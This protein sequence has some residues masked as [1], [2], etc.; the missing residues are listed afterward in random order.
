[1]NTNTKMTKKLQKILSFSVAFSLVIQL[2]GITPLTEALAATREQ[3]ANWFKRSNQAETELS[4][5]SPEVEELQTKLDAVIQTE[6]NLKEAGE[7]ARVK[8][9]EQK[10]VLLSSPLKPASLFMLTEKTNGHADYIKKYGVYLGVEITPEQYDAWLDENRNKIENLNANS[11]SAEQEAYGLFYKIPNH[12]LHKEEI[13]SV[14]E[15][16]SY[17]LDGIAN[18]SIDSRWTDIVTATLEIKDLSNFLAEGTELSDIGTSEQIREELDKKYQE[19]I[20][21]K[22]ELNKIEREKLEDIFVLQEDTATQKSYQDAS[23]IINDNIAIITELEAKLADVSKTKQNLEEAA[24][25]AREKLAETKKVYLQKAPRLA[26]LSML[27][28]A[29]GLAE[30]IEQGVF[31]G[32][33]INISKYKELLGANTSNYNNQVNQIDALENE[34][35]DL[36]NGGELSKQETLTEKQTELIA[37]QQELEAKYGLTY[38]ISNELLYKTAIEEIDDW[39]EYIL[40][41][42]INNDGWIDKIEIILGAINTY[43]LSDYF[44]DIE[45]TTERRQDITT[46]FEGNATKEELDD[47]SNIEI[48]LTNSRDDVEEALGTML[49]ILPRQAANTLIPTLDTGTEFFKELSRAFIRIEISSADSALLVPLDPENPEDSITLVTA[50]VTDMEGEPVIGARVTFSSGNAYFPDNSG[51]FSTTA[52]QLTVEDPDVSK[53][54]SGIA[55]VEYAAIDDKHTASQYEE[56]T[57]DIY[58]TATIELEDGTISKPVFAHLELIKK[59]RDALKPSPLDP[60]IEKQ[61]DEEANEKAEELNFTARSNP[62]NLL[63][64]M[65]A[66]IIPNDNLE[67]NTEGIVTIRVQGAYATQV[68]GQ[69]DAKTGEPK[70]IDENGRPIRSAQQ[71]RITPT[72]QLFKRVSDGEEM[73]AGFRFPNKKDRFRSWTI[74]GSEERDIDEKQGLVEKTITWSI[75]EKVERTLILNPNVRGIRDIDILAEL[76][77]G[78]LNTD[79]ELVNTLREQEYSEYQTSSIANQ[80]RLAYTKATTNELQNMFRW[81]LPVHAQ[82]IQTPKSPPSSKM[83]G[84]PGLTPPPIIQPPDLIPDGEQDESQPS[85]DEKPQ[86]DE[87][88][89]ISENNKPE[90]DGDQQLLQE[91]LDSDD[92]QLMRDDSRLVQHDEDNNPL[93]GQDRLTNEF[94]LASQTVSFYQDNPFPEQEVEFELSANQTEVEKGEV[95]I[96]LTGKLTGTTWEITH[97]EN[98]TL[99]RQSSNS[100]SLHGFAKISVTSTDEEIGSVESELVEINQSGIFRANYKTPKARGD[101]T[102]TITVSG[103][104]AF[105]INNQ[106]F[107]SFA[108]SVTIEHGQPIISMSDDDSRFLLGEDRNADRILK[109]YGSRINATPSEFFRA[110]NIRV[111]AALGNYTQELGTKISDLGGMG[112]GGWGLGALGVPGFDYRSNP[113]WKIDFENNTDEWERDQPMIGQF[114]SNNEFEDALGK[115]KDDEPNPQD[116]GIGVETRYVVINT[117]VTDTSGNPIT[118]GIVRGEA[119]NHLIAAEGEKDEYFYRGGTTNATL[120]P[121]IN[122]SG[123]STFYYAPGDTKVGSIG[124]LQFSNTYSTKGKRRTLEVNVE[125]PVVSQEEALKNKESRITITIAEPRYAEPEHEDIRDC[126]KLFDSK[127]AIKSSEEVQRCISRIRKGNLPSRPAGENNYA[128]ELEQYQRLSKYAYRLTVAVKGAKD[129]GD[130]PAGRTVQIHGLPVVTL[131]P[132]PDEKNTPAK[133]DLDI[134]DD[135]SNGAEFPGSSSPMPGGS[136][137]LPGTSVEQALDNFSS[138]SFVLDKNGQVGATLDKEILILPTRLPAEL[139]VTYTDSNSVKHSNHKKIKQVRRV[140]EKIVEESDKSVVQEIVDSATGVTVRL[141]TTKSNAKQGEIVPIKFTIDVPLDVSFPDENSPMI[142]TLQDKYEEDEVFKTMVDIGSYINPGMQIIKLLLKQEARVQLFSILAAQRTG[143]GEITFRGEKIERIETSR[144]G[145]PKNKHFPVYYDAYS[146]GGVK[147][148]TPNQCNDK[149]AENYNPESTGDDDCEYKVALDRVT[150][151]LRVKITTK[152]EGQHIG[153][154]QQAK[155]D[156]NITLANED[157]GMENDIRKDNIKKIVYWKH[158][159]SNIGKEQDASDR[160][161]G[162]VIT[163]SGGAS[164]RHYED[165]IY[166]KKGSSKIDEVGIAVFFYHIITFQGSHT[167]E[168]IPYSRTWYS[169]IIGFLG[170]IFTVEKKLPL[171]IKIGLEGNEAPKQDKTTE[172]AR[173]LDGEADDQF[174]DDGQPDESEETEDKSDISKDEQSDDEQLDE[175]SDDYD[176]SHF[177]D[178]KPFGS[179]V[180]VDRLWNE[181]KESIKNSSLLSPS[182]NEK[183]YEKSGTEAARYL[184]NIVRLDLKKGP[185]QN[186]PEVKRLADASIKLQLLAELFKVGEGNNSEQEKQFFERVVASYFKTNSFEDIEALKK[187][188][189]YK[190]DQIVNTVLKNYEDMGFDPRTSKTNIPQLDRL[191]PDFDRTISSAKQTIRASSLLTS[192]NKEQIIR[193]LERIK[194]R[195]DYSGGLYYSYIKSRIQQ[196]TEQ[197][198]ASNSDVHALYQML[199]D[200]LLDTLLI[201]TLGNCTEQQKISAKNWIDSARNGQVVELNKLAQIYHWSEYQSNSHR[202]LQ[203]IKEQIIENRGRMGLT[204][205]TGTDDAGDEMPLF[206]GGGISSALD[207]LFNIFGTYAGTDSTATANPVVNIWNAAINFLSKLFTRN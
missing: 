43:A 79:K 160:I 106:N 161:K 16:I 171:I 107:G 168:I 175:P 78:K 176:F 105:D 131:I 21:T 102:I 99:T 181:T 139:Y 196:A 70:Y 126:Q 11:E 123:E 59:N 184:F 104:E 68:I 101:R 187:L 201:E 153:T 48:D 25:S 26:S 64:D 35:K 29:G 36:Q 177:D 22:T 94:V 114:E 51:G 206:G 193:Y 76:V 146:S 40:S 103:D 174:E 132:H 125:I 110:H 182:Q 148:G 31:D 67:G 100:Q 53:A 124:K 92:S 155:D 61:K 202:R 170:S 42:D 185:F 207:N 205:E 32:V 75:N 120:E 152:D 81:L 164:G 150:P 188:N 23:K 7:A 37:K 138:T 128:D 28:S 15:D 165:T 179:V 93:A 62:G 84:P 18:H 45:G 55:Q 3:T 111:Y 96:Q 65:T 73:A 34:I 87:E 27:E 9:E 86:P 200:I 57:V 158:Y 8:L 41:R 97:G 169:Q 173:S 198:D 38:V 166:I 154:V 46:L 134:I 141:S 4:I 24:I 183:L 117:E 167:K 89:K 157:S 58:A 191:A 133:K 52:S 147:E 44:S 130:N 1:M 119:S 13:N 98:N 121:C 190:F 5:L 192:E 122:Q 6:T 39:D 19:L 91:I 14:N 145:L 66:D 72:L 90:L 47:I 142:K 189:S 112:V 136:I 63:F 17:I 195:P 113:N 118:E 30:Y 162:P 71:P 12:I 178:T 33:E 204:S 156:Y 109:V 82:E 137:D 54:L 83:P 194:N 20:K 159:S 85:D 95:T 172:E 151:G 144:L 88:Q 149:N 2:V 135:A 199:N 56:D 116:Y 203:S 49:N 60:E 77:A 108:A 127:D 140:R 180:D 143:T 197:T 129:S 163:A 186:D 50:W 69:R 80:P 74:T 10:M 115:W